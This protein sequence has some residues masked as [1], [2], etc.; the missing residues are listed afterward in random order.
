MVP[1]MGLRAF[2]GNEVVTMVCDFLRKV[3]VFIVLVEDIV[4]LMRLPMNVAML[5]RKGSYRMVWMLPSC[6]EGNILMEGNA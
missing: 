4:G 3:A 5:P 1:T 2:Q 6:H